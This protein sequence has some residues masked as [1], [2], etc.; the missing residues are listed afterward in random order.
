VISSLRSSDIDLPA[1]IAELVESLLNDIE[2]AL[3]EGV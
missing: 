2:R 1:A 3:V